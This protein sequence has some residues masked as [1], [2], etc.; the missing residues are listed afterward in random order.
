MQLKRI[1]M[2]AVAV[3]GVV[4]LLALS[5]PDEESFNRWMK[6]S[7]VSDADSG[8]DKAKG[9]AL[10][11]Q[12]KWTSNST[13]RVLWATVEARQGGVRHRYLGILWMWLDLG[14]A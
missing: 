3:V 6:S 7:Q 4:L 2:F 13:D 9:S 1:V 11:T 14:E 12:A 8:L 10:A 5:C